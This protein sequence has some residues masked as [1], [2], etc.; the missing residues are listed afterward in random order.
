MNEYIVELN[1]KEG[2]A[3]SF[4]DDPVKCIYCNQLR[5]SYSEYL[6]HK[7]TCIFTTKFKIN[8]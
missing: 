3:T 7:K 4:I 8:K 2:Y 1:K 5:P 6:E